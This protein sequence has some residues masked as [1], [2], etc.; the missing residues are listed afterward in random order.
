MA[1]EPPKTPGIG[2]DEWVASVEGRREGYRGLSGVVRARIERVPAPVLYAAF[3]AAAA[4][5]PVFTNNGYVLR[6]GFNTLIFMLLALGLNIVV[7]FAGLLDLGY[8]AFFG[9][10]A[11]GYAM[12]ASSQFNLHWPTPAILPV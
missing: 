10:G 1:G 6:V 3:G 11:Y 12:L 2:K 8:V 5:V 9:I 4:L 7:G